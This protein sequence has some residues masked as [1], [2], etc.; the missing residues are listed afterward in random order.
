MVI[1]L[2]SILGKSSPICPGNTSSLVVYI[3]EQKV[4]AVSS[5]EAFP[6]R[7]RIGNALVS[8]IAYIVR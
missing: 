7:G 2:S 1:D 4:G 5:I 8:Y 6:L 3:Y